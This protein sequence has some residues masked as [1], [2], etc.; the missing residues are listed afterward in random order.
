MKSRILV[1]APLCGLVLVVGAVFLTVIEA[2][3]PQASAVVTQR[4]ATVL[5]AP[6]VQPGKDVA[7]A[8]RA[9]LSGTVRLWPAREGRPVVIQRRVGNG[10]WSEVTTRRQDA[11]GTVGFTGASSSRGGMPYEYRGV[12]PRWRDL[13]PV[14]SAPQKADDWK[15][16]FSDDFDDVTST[17]WSDR[18]SSARSRTCAKVGDPRAST[19]KGGTLRL[20]V[21]VDPDRRD[22][23]CRSEAGRFRY[24]LNGQVSTEHAPHAFTRGFFAARIKFPRAR[25]QH[26]SF[27]LQPLQ[28]KRIE[29]DHASSG[30]EI[31]V[32]EFFG[33]GYPKGGL[34]SFVYNY[35][36][37]NGTKKLGGMSPRATQTLRAGDAWW[38]SYHVF[39][40]EWTRRAYVFRVDGREYLRIKRGVSGID[41]Y[42]ILS[43]LTSD[44]ELAQAQRLGVT[45][46]GTMHVDWTRVWQR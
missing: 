15:L 5:T 38:K 30:A 43:L 25:G 33:A 18:P 16:R 27:W 39:S 42:M 4:A 28:P 9:R 2:R 1:I 24:Y 17:R 35:G 10:P 44:W 32:V 3:Q 23:R 14:A 8:S 46:G 31:D 34:A 19:I 13:S 20:K 26:G 22:R 12:A 41:Q 37:H 7:R 21:R 11:A 29:G 36:L 45:P 6:V 40:L